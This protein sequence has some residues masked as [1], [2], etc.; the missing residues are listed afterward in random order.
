MSAGDVIA[1]I[2][3]RPSVYQG[4]LPTMALRQADAILAALRAAGYALVPVEPTVDMLQC[5]YDAFRAVHTTGISGMTI[6]AQMR[7]QSI[8]H[9]ACYRAMIAAA[10]ETDD[11]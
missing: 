4:K 1:R 8:R 9:D 3:T 6:E 10:Q 2:L 11:D 7:A 5:G